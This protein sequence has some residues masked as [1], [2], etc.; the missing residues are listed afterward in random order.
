MTSTPTPDYG[1][2]SLGPID[3]INPWTEPPYNPDWHCTLHGDLGD[4]SEHPNGCPACHDN[5][6][7]LQCL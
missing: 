7:Y 5:P 6:P 3:R 1:A 2:P 4:Y